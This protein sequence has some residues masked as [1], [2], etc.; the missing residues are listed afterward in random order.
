MST[1]RAETE[2][3][4][5]GLRATGWFF[6]PD[7]GGRARRTADVVWLLFGVLLVFVTAIGSDQTAWFT[8]FL[9]E[10][11]AAAVAAG[12]TTINVPDT[13][14]YAL[15]IENA[16]LFDQLYEMG[17]NLRLQHRTADQT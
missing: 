9:A 11:L 13:V 5:H 16:A 2:T 4:D 15:P 8:D 3:K 1:D 6:V 14:G 7:E 12:A 17:K 10:V